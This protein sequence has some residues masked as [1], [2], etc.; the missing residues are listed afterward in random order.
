MICFETV[1]KRFNI[2]KLWQI[3]VRDVGSG[4]FTKG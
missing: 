3:R 1:M 2:A 4:K